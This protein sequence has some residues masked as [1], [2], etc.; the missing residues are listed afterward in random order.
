[1][2]KINLIKRIFKTQV[3]QYLSQILIIFLFIVVS[4]LATASVAWLLDPAIKKIL[5]H[6]ID[7]V[8]YLASQYA[9]PNEYD[10]M[11]SS[12]GATGTN[13][14]TS[15]EYTMYINEIP[16]NEL[17]RWIKMERERFDTPVLRLFHTELETVYEEFNRYQDMDGQRQFFAMFKGL[18][19]NHPLGIDRIGYPEHLKNPSVKNIY[20]FYH[21]WYVPNN[22]SFHLSGDL[23]YEATVQMIDRSWGNMKSK[24]L[25]KLDLPKLT[26]IT[27]VGERH[28]SG[29]DSESVIFGYRFGGE[30]SEDKLYVS[31]I[32]YI[33][34]N[35]V[36]GLIDIN[37]N[38]KQ[39]IL[40]GVCSPM[41][42]TDY[43]IHYFY[44]QPKQNQSLE[45]VRDLLLSQIDSIKEGKFEEWMMEAA[46]NDMR[47]QSV[48]SL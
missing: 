42:L 25:P 10:K 7:S 46:I 14:G 24:E 31:L 18:F 26:P 9:I 4:A 30:Q 47:L 6:K 17:E 44:G 11:V 13:A 48:K 21:T 1:M 27:E 12:I 23:D 20:E 39:E 43:G 35:S 45:E 22:M 28:V 16:S 41:F 34:A 3:K 32:D 5:Y 38:Q 19:P 36:A 33:L 2:E 8:S 37:L 15:W 40:Y 29:P